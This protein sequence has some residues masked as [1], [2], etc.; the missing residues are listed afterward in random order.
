[1]YVCMY[2]Y[3]FLYFSEDELIDM[4]AGKEKTDDL[5][6]P[7]A[8]FKDSDGIHTQ[9]IHLYI[10]SYILY[11]C[12]SKPSSF[13]GDDQRRMGYFVG[14]QC[15]ASGLHKINTSC[16]TYIHTYIRIY[17]HS[18]IHTNRH[19]YTKVQENE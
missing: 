5:R 9:N 18:Y 17:I 14:V 4:L 13:G 1:M 6:M 10:H 16:G 12:S 2:V 7:L 19:T 11:P 15:H 3:V 8:I